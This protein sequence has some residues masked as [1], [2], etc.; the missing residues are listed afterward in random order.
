[1]NA[2]DYKRLM[3]RRTTELNVAQGKVFQHLG[4]NSEFGI[5]AKWSEVPR[6]GAKW[7]Q[8]ELDDLL[9]RLKEMRDAANRLLIPADIAALAWIHGR[10]AT[11]VERKLIETIGFNK[12]AGVVQMF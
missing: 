1:M 4:A 2:I 7:T 11:A 8:A 9:V 6:S 5:S 10:S 3:I 12:Y